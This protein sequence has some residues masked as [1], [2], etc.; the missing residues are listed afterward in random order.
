MSTSPEASTGQEPWQWDEAVWRGHAERVRAGRDLT[1]REWPGGAR[2]AVA[3]SFDPDHE[4]LSL[5]EGDTSPGAMGRGEFGSRVG[6]RRILRLLEEFQIPATFFIPAVSALLHPQ[7]AKD[8][9]AAGHEI[10]AHG[11]IHERNALLTPEDELDLNRRSL[12]VLENLVGQRP[13][14][15]RTPSADFSDSTV[16]ILQELG[17]R[18]DTSLMADDMP[19]EILS[20]RRPTGI[21]E[22]P[23][24]WIRDD[25]PYFMMTRFGPHRPYTPPRAWAEIMKD[26]FDSAYADGAVF[27]M[28]CHP[29]IIGHR[30]RMHALRGLVEHMKSHENVWYATH[31][32]IADY[33]WRNADQDPEN[34]L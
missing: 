34:R 5:R 20:N 23:M 10:G 6:S 28:V 4:T 21:V 16:E 18:Y 30:S 22:V 2:M 31:G 13:V 15:I 3:L 29:H 25:A 32:E 14:G 8:Y 9:A 1:P 33:V 19:Y 7:E 12:D 27:Q 26:E 17:F 24:E 11:W